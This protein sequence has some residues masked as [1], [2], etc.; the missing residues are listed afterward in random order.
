MQSLTPVQ[1]G[2]I[3]IGVIVLLVIIWWLWY[4]NEYDNSCAKSSCSTKS[5]SI[6]TLEDVPQDSREILDNYRHLEAR[7]KADNKQ[8][9]FKK[10][11]TELSSANTYAAARNRLDAIVESMDAE[12]G[13]D[14]RILVAEPD[15]TVMYDSAKG[16][17]NTYQN[18]VDKDINE[19]HN[20]RASIMTAQM[21]GHREFAYETKVS[22]TTGNVE[23]YVAKRVGRL[24]NN[25]GTVRYSIVN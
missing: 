17:E 1:I 23:S 25:S 11:I 16:A 15:G 2:G 6:V 4:D 14:T 7:M 8:Y 20:T 5:S 13:A 3:V 24:S 21:L 22:N 10:I 18:F 12:F 19:N 9:D